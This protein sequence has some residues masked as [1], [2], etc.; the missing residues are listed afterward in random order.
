MALPLIPILIAGGVLLLAGRKPP[1]KNGNGAP[2]PNV[3]PMTMEELFASS[4]IGLT[5]GTDTLKITLPE[6]GPGSWTLYTEAIGGDPIIVVEEAHVEGGGEEGDYGTH[7]YTI[8][9]ER[10]GQIKADFVN[11]T[12]GDDSEIFHEHSV[13]LNI[14]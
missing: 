10:A 4:E 3:I 1:K 14:A 6:T 8:R 2:T 12:P 11:A 7:Q 13:I 9:A 5:G